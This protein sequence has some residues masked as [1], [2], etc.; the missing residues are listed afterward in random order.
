MKKPIKDV[1]F[2]IYF[3]IMI[4]LFLLLIFSFVILYGNSYETFSVPTKS[5]NTTTTSPTNSVPNKI[6]NNTSDT[7]PN[8]QTTTSP[9]IGP[10]TS[11]TI[12]P[13]TSPTTKVFD[14]DTRDKILG[15]TW[16]TPNAMSPMVANK[17]T[18]SPVTKDSLNNMSKN[19]STMLSTI[20]NNQSSVFK[21]F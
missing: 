14:P 18:V 17:P 16:Y 19:T 8:N 15:N 1:L 2:G 6:F 13:T 20:Q 9:T 7:G 10:T 5:T 4:I 21:L 12:G 11:P 3:S